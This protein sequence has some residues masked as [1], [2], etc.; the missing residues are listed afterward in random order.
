MLTINEI[1]DFLISLLICCHIV[2]SH[3]TFAKTI[4]QLFKSELLKVLK[5]GK[6]FLISVLT[7]KTLISY[8]PVSLKKVILQ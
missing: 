1:R 2:I 7:Y 6:C 4:T 5:R 8:F 3:H